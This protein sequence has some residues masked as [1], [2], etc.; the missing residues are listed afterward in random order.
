MSTTPRTLIFD[1]ET[2]PLDFETSFDDAQKHYLLHNARSDQEA[3]Y[4]KTSG[5]LNPLMGQ[6]ACIGT[7]V[8]ETQSG[9]ALFLAPEASEEVVETP[10]M[11]IR[12]KAFTDERALLEHFWEKLPKGYQTVVTFNG[13]NF[14]CPFLMLRSAVLGIRPSL[15]LMG[16]TRYEHK[17]TEVGENKWGGAA[18]VD[19][20]E[21]LIFGA[22]FDRFG[23]T[24]KFNLDFYTKAFGIPSPKSATISGD[25]VPAFYREGRMREVAEYCMRDV[26]A[27]SQLYA[28]WDEF[29]RF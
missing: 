21:K 19:L 15:N 18:H 14:D 28:K 20:Q 13:R 29:L 4:I 25:K 2:I 11:T 12:Y 16:G 8:H 23:A 27:T 5:S 3:E 26:R 9:A 17:V 6:V 1:I 24:R 22:G 7:L 10:E